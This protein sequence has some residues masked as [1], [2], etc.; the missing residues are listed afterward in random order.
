MSVGD[1][2]LKLRELLK[3]YPTRDD[4]Y[5][6]AGQPLYML[7]HDFFPAHLGLYEPERESVATIVLG[8]DWGNK[9]SFVQWLVRSRH[10]VNATVAGTDRLLTKA[11]F[12]LADC[13]YS[14]AWPLMRA[15][16]K[17]KGPHPMRDDAALTN[18]YRQYLRHTLEELDIKLVISLG[19][20]S[21]W[22]LGP[23]C[24]PNWAL[25]QLDS[26]RDVK[27]RHF[28]LEPL[29]RSNGIVF[30]SATHPSYGAANER[31]RDL[32][33]PYGSEVGMLIHAR[34]Q[35]GILDAPDWVGPAPA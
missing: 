17:E 32:P 23:F 7:G 16:G 21:A 11:G 10:Q 30:V 13:F 24:G 19:H 35:A 4:C 15:G 3:D 8:S 31:R 29:R 33:A 20:A 12:V 22:F 27:I 34:R 28:D 6:F 1:K 18:A 25:G 9:E 14:N 5:S 26:S 2:V